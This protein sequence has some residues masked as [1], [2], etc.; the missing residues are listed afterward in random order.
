MRHYAAQAAGQCL[1]VKP[2]DHRRQISNNLL[3]TF[4]ELLQEY[5]RE[6]SQAPLKGL[7]FVPHASKNICIMPKSCRCIQDRQAKLYCCTLRYL[8]CH[9]LYS[10]NL[11][12]RVC[13]S[14]VT[15][16]KIYA[17][18][19]R[20]RQWL[21]RENMPQQIYSVLQPVSRNLS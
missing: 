8:Q 15:T 3:Y 18:A 21:S 9:T 17:C 13:G 12:E 7:G 20:K 11:G 2:P 14:C 1:H 10:L 19:G 5:L 16:G 6:I 4:L